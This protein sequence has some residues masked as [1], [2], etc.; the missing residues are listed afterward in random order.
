MDQN[1]NNGALPSSQD[2]QTDEMAELYVKKDAQDSVVILCTIASGL[3]LLLTV[4]FVYGIF[5]KL[6]DR[7]IFLVECPKSYELDSPV[8]LPVLK[9]ASPK[10]KDQ[11]VRGFIRKFVTRQFPRNKHDTEEF[12]RFT[13]ERSRGP[14]KKMFEERYS[15]LDKFNQLLDGGYVYSFYPK[16]S[17]DVRIRA[18]S[19]GRWVVEVDGT[20]VHQLKEFE[21]RTFPT[22]RY[23][24]E[25]GP[26]TLENPDGLYVVEANTEVYADYVSGE[27]K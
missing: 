27:K 5:D 12:L 15:N 19:S 13:M 20:L 9:D 25:A 6:H 24:V 26:V 23:V 22:L 14:V 7:S 8:L 17:L 1:D 16:N 3:F 2:N 10:S 11:W 18:A 4:H 21:A